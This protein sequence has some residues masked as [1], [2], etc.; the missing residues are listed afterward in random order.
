MVALVSYFN[1]A[2]KMLKQTLMD[3]VCGQWKSKGAQQGLSL[4]A[5][6]MPSVRN[7]YTSRSIASTLS[8]T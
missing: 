1:G 5:K 7:V 8:I 2:V 3:I 4:V 6:D